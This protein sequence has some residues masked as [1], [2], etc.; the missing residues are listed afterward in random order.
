V[1]LKILL[2]LS[3]NWWMFLLQTFIRQSLKWPDSH[4]K[5]TELMTKKKNSYHMEYWMS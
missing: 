4:N 3:W 2:L 5:N 1:R